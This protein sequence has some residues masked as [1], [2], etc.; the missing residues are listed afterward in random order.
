MSSDP[1]ADQL[2]GFFFRGLG[3]SSRQMLGRIFITTIHL[4][5]IQRIHEYWKLNQQT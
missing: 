3:Q 5:I 4:T 2:D 1:G